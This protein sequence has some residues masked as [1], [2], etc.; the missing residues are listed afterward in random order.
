MV[1]NCCFWL[2][3]GL[4]VYLLF[5]F[6][7]LYSNIFFYI[8]LLKG[9]PKSACEVDYSDYSHICEDAANYLPNHLAGGSTSCDAYMGAYSGSGYPLAGES[10]SSTYDCS[11]KSDAIIQTVTNI[12]AYGC[13]GG[14]SNG[15][16][17]VVFG[18]L[19]YLF[20]CLFVYLFICLNILYL[21]SNIFFYILHYSTQRK[22]EIYLRRRGPWPWRGL[23]PMCW[24]WQKGHN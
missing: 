12:A 4:F 16:A 17:I 9:N 20:I 18:C 23:K 21:Y 13:C 19:V 5:V 6:V 15:K 24:H 11:G 7:Y 22:P 10:F 8:L 3:L 14:N 1:S 2:L